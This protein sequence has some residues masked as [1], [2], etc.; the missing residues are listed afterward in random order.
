MKEEINDRLLRD[1]QYRKAASISF[2]S[3]TNAAIELCKGLDIDDEKTK[4]KIVEIRDWF[5]REHQDY[6]AKVIA[7]IGQFYKVGDSIV[8]LK[9][10]KT[11]DELRSV[12]LLLSED[13]RRDGEI[14]K[15]AQELK[16]NFNLYEKSQN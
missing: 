16:K 14:I 11:F 15:V 9:N 12:W 4:K 7:N 3:A 10:A 2:F 6:Y 13:E 5:L 8:K 1:A